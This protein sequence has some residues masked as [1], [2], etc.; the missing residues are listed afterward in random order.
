MQNEKGKAINAQQ[1]GLSDSAL[2]KSEEKPTPTKFQGESERERIPNGA[3]KN[4]QV[5]DGRPVPMH[6]QNGLQLDGF[7]PNPLA[8]AQLSTEQPQGMH[9]NVPALGDTKTEQL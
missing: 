7:N 1:D 8:N 2:P 5:P 4:L 3:S 6:R 9:T